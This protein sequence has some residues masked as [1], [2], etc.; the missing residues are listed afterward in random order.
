MQGYLISRRTNNKTKTALCACTMH[1]TT[2]HPVAACLTSQHQLLHISLIEV[3]IK[4]M[5]TTTM[6]NVGFLS[7]PAELICYIL[8]LLT[9]RDLCRCAIA[10]CKIFRDAAQDSVQIQHKLELFAQGFTEI[11]T[12]DSI[13]FVKKNSSLKKSAFM[14]RSDFHVNT[15]FQEA[16][17]TPHAATQETQFMKCGLWWMSRDDDL[18]IHECSTNATRTWPNHSLSPMP[19]HDLVSVIVDPLQD[20]VVTISL[21]HS[22]DVHHSVQA[23]HIFWLEIRTLSSEAPHPDSACTSLDCRHHFNARGI[24]HVVFMK[25]PAICGDRIVVPYCTSTDDIWTKLMFIQ[26]VDWRK[27]QAE[28]VSPVIEKF[29]HS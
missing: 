16:V 9:P 3:M 21:P 5:I 27:G 14:S 20:L 29:Y 17:P 24:Q 11:I 4:I 22:I 13:D 12:R 18:L 1:I 28:C 8:F 19:Q 2:G 6:A 10:T 25:E 15:V 23:H 7:L 26:V